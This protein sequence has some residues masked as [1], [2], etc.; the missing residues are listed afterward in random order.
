MGSRS[1][2]LI[3]LSKNIFVN[4]VTIIWL[5]HN[6]WFHNIYY[7]SIC[8]LKSRHDLE[9]KVSV[10]QTL[11][12]ILLYIKLHVC[13]FGK[14]EK[15]CTPNTVSHANGVANKLCT[16]ICLYSHSVF[17]NKATNK[18]ILVFCLYGVYNP[19][20]TIKVS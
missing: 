2:N 13:K 8:Q 14:I 12:I 16:E 15:S 1:L 6:I 18:F 3:F 10:T 17:G 5:V 11:I 19:I 20:N 7:A 4:P 9:N